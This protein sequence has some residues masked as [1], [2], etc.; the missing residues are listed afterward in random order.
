MKAEEVHIMK[1][2][3]ALFLLVSV[4][5]ALAACG[6]PAE[7]DPA[8]AII[9][10][11]QDANGNIMEFDAN[12]G[13]TVVNGSM[14]LTCSWQYV[15]ADGNFLVDYTSGNARA[16]VEQ[17]EGTGLVLTWQGVEFKRIG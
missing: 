1:R 15:A 12:K 17:K 13:G 7:V 3:I 9:G 14:K 8:T 4:V 2:I 11:W 5:L 10:K 6:A 16:T